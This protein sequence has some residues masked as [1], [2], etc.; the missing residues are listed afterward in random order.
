LNAFVGQRFFGN[1]APVAAPTRTASANSSSLR[2]ETLQSG[3]LEL[4]ADQDRVQTGGSHNQNTIV[5]P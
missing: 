4:L 2:H 5:S 3:G 1:D